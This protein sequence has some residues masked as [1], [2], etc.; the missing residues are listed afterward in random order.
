MT[1]QPHPRDVNPTADQY[2]PEADTVFVEI[3]GVGP[4]PVA[5]LGQRLLARLI[6]SVVY[7]VVFLV[8]AGTGV[9]PPVVLAAYEA[10]LFGLIYEFLFVAYRGAT[11][12]KM[13]LG[14]KVVD[15][16][17]GGLIG[18]RR[19]LVRQLIPFVGALVCFV[20]ALLVYASPLFD[21]SGRIQGWHDKAA[22]DLVVKMRNR[23]ERSAQP[24]GILMRNHL[25][26][27]GD[28]AGD[29]QRAAPLA[30]APWWPPRSPY[31]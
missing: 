11:L 21:R 25:D 14:I 10:L 2:T 7:V 1:Q 23:K 20:G 30:S 19:A 13:A 27:V 31:W 12:G 22:H 3:P 17:T 8:L 28:A 24:E 5:S 18:Q 26:D 6:D 9:V 15:Q 16:R 29:A 4:V